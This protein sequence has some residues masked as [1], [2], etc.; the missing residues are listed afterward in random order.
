[1]LTNVRV[2]GV[3]KL[4]TVWTALRVPFTVLCA[5]FFAVI[6]VFSATCRAVRTGPACSVLAQTANATMTENNAFMV[7][8]IS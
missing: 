1:M 5:T 4:T 3:K 8:K 6:A 2:Y 7:L